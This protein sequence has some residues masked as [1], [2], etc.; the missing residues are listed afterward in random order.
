MVE[1]AEHRQEKQRIM[2]CLEEALEAEDLDE[3]N[4][5]IRQVLQMIE[6]VN[7]Y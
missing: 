1:S 3:M 5:H 2:E 6:I 4:F 7:S